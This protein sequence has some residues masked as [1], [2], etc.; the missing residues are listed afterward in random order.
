M[1]GSVN[2]ALLVGRLGRSPEVKYTP[3]GK[4]VAKFSMATDERFKDSQGNVQK[5][6]EWHN[7]VAWGKLAEVCGRYLE[8]GSYIYIEGSI[9]TQSWEDRQTGQKRSKTEI[10]AQRMTM[11]GGGHSKPDGETEPAQEVRPEIGRAVAE[12]DLITDEDISF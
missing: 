11:L 3:S 9:Q 12:S 1:S 8:K 10:N 4:A 6:T 2:K 5:R 7:I